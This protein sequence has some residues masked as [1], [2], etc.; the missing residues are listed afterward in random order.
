M[1]KMVMLAALLYLV[2]EAIGQSRPSLSGPEYVLNSPSNMF[3]IHWTDSGQDSTTWAYAHNIAL[4][5]DSSLNVQCGQMGFFCP[6]PDQSAGG[7]DRYD[8]YVLGLSQGVPG[9]M[10]TTG[11]Y[12]PPDSSHDCSASHI[13]LSSSIS[14]ASERN[15]AVAG[16]FAQAVGAAYDCQESAGFTAAYAAWMEEQVYPDAD[17]YLEFLEQENPLEN[18]WR[19]F[20]TLGASDLPW[21]F[22]ADQRWGYQSVRRIWELCAAQSGPNTS[23]AIQ[24]MMLENGTTIQKFQMD[25]GAW[26]WFTGDN[27]FAECGMYGPD[28]AQWQPGPMVLPAHDISALPAQGGFVPGFEPERFGLNWIRLDLTGHQGQWID[29]AFDGC[30]DT[31]WRLGVILHGGESGLYYQWHLCDPVTG[32]K[33]IAVNSGNWEQAVFFPVCFETGDP[34]HTFSYSV[35]SQGTGIAD[36][37]DGGHHLQFST[38]P[39]GADGEIQ[40]SIQAKG[41]VRVTLHDLSGRIVAVLMDGEAAAGIHTLGI[42]QC[43]ADLASGT[44]I[45]LLCTDSDT[46]TGRLVF[47][48]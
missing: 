29:F 46:E 31:Q 32:E 16:L 18:P 5:A 27:W 47:F 2:S 7:D 3:S 14:E 15:C 43:D 42:E 33:A 45:V 38:N 21:V 26:R 9:Y 25:Y 13:C 28:A 4:A 19:E 30:D 6:P 11:E 22:M 48:P 24:G 35:A 8:I 41:Y 37:P 36:S 20:G 1:A 17:H 12:Q 44:Y 39:M 34:A 40:F 23:E 10:S